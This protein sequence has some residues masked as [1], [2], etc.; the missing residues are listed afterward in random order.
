MG[1]LCQSGC[2]AAEDPHESPLSTRGK[3]VC[4]LFPEKKFPI[5][6]KLSSHLISKRR[7]GFAKSRCG[8]SHVDQLP[9]EAVGKGTL[10][11][12]F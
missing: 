2:G 8:L 9:R 10:M 5:S 1:R 3:A 4:R 7:L 6:E 11:S 12:V